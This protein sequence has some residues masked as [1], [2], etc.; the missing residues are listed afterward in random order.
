MM[1]D[2]LTQSST[3]LIYGI[4]GTVVLTTV[5]LSAFTENN[6]QDSL[7]HTSYLLKILSGSSRYTHLY[8]HMHMLI[9]SSKYLN[10]ILDK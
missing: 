8:Q 6:Q 3:S 2:P 5:P 10:I 9:D 1:L 7:Y 4:E